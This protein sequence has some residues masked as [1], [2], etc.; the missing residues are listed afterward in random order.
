MRRTW[1][2]AAII[3]LLGLAIL[4][5]VLIVLNRNE[6]EAYQS[7]RGSM[8][9]GFGEL[10][11]VTWQGETYREKAAITTLLIAGID[12]PEAALDTN[13]SDYRSGGQAD[14]LMIIAIDHTD[15]KIYQLQIDRDT[16][17]EVD[18]LGV[19]GNEVGTR[20]LQICLSHSFGATPEDNAKY[21]M[22]AVRNLLDGLEI[23][24]YYMI[25]YSAMGVLNDALGG[26]TV[27]VD[28]DMTSV[29]PAWTQ[30]STV[31]LHGQEAEAFVR[32][33]KTVGVG[34]NEERMTRQ[35]EFMSKAIAQMKKK[36]S[37]DLG[38]GEGLLNSLSTLAVTNMT[39]KRLV[40]ELNQA[41]KYETMPIDHPAGEYKI[42][43]G[44][45]MEFYMEDG[46]AVRWVL[47]HLY[48]KV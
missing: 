4:A 24:G 13:T 10:K 9:E 37:A 22:R 7:R 15:K 1:I 27:N 5:T 45:F 14:F 29:N 33:R 47:D 39:S 30:G 41:Y 11:T 38:F 36:I 19:F 8:S 17:T 35:A 23:D 43:E 34:T 48:T 26:V 28:Y 25:D 20:I 21:T 46:E 3:S 2:K 16:M 6:D 31:T 42:G 32:A 44:E 18:I 40:D 12:K